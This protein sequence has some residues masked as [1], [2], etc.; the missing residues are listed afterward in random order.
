MSKI[1]EIL[2]DLAQF[3][4]TF[5]DVRIMAGQPVTIKTPHG[6]V[7]MQGV[8]DASETEVSVSGR[9]FEDF[10]SK[11]GEQ[12]TQELRER[13]QLDRAIPLNGDFRARINLFRSG[14]GDGYGL[15]ARY[16][17][18]DPT[19]FADTGL[20][21]QLLKLM[22]ARS[23]LFLVCGRTGAGK[24]ST[25]AS[26][27]RYVNERYPVHAVTIE[28][29]IEYQYKSGMAFFTQREVGIDCPSF[30]AGVHAALRQAPD[31]I[32]IGEIRDRGTAEA[33]LRAALSGHLVLATIH[34]D[35]AVS[36]IERMFSFLPDEAGFVAL[37]LRSAL[38][39]SVAQVIL[40]TEDKKRFV[41]AAEILSGEADQVGA[42]IS[43]AVATHDSLKN[44]EAQLLSN[45]IS[46]SN[47]FNLHLRQLVAKGAIS[48][49]T[50][51]AASPHKADLQTRLNGSSSRA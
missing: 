5:T 46:G 27:L 45:G 26:L 4:G 11:L 30:A 16:Q 28:E 12:A 17:P 2:V 51:L 1:K 29:P 48:R 44:L 43:A 40:P 13:G 9:D 3:E 36:A 41:V 21:V 14:G 7:A 31:I 15:L 47:H 24:T 23:G 37:A 35:R 8:E 25:L 49:E 34:G 18:T 6:W 38:L 20:P 19:P 50:A 42:A 22:D 33:A 32:Q 39:A 10:V